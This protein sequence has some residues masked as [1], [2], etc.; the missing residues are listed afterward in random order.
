MWEKI[1]Y[2]HFNNFLFE[3]YQQS[4]SKKLYR[5]FL[6]KKN[7]KNMKFNFLILKNM[8][9]FFFFSLNYYLENLE[10]D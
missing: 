9:K 5:N 8:Y 1:F 3:I 7:R 6:I 2:L 4:N 10:K